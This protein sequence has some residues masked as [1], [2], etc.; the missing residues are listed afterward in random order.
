MA[1]TKMITVLLI[2]CMLGVIINVLGAEG[3]IEKIEGMLWESL[4]PVP[5]S[6]DD[7]PSKITRPSY[8]CDHRMAFDHDSKMVYMIG[9]YN[10]EEKDY[11]QDMDDL[12]ELTYDTSSKFTL[13]SMKW[14]LHQT[15]EA[16]R[17]HVALGVGFHLIK[18]DAG[19]Q[20]VMI[21]GRKSTDLSDYYYL[22]QS[23]DI[24]SNTWIDQTAVGSVPS[25]RYYIQSVQLN[26]TH[27]FVFGGLSYTTTNFDDLWLLD[28]S[29]NGAYKWTC[30]SEFCWSD[31]NLPGA[32]PGNKGALMDR[33]A[34]C[35]VD[36]D[37]YDEILC[38]GN[39]TASG[40]W[41]PFTSSNNSYPGVA[42][43]AAEGNIGFID[44]EAE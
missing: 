5:F 21:H 33:W 10:L 8:R 38:N 42:F 25:K 15:P 34:A 41:Q 28:V 27:I 30:L 39:Q 14:V 24:A 18:N 29:Q 1:F 36:S 31:D 20:L 13:K 22:T 43:G 16:N 12:Y 7:Y 37:V 26:D 35:Q 44:T 11:P 19:K 3:S 17:D 23:N 32:A 4:S 2:N 40:E 9:G 6:N